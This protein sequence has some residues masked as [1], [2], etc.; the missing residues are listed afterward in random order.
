MGGPGQ[1]G[2]WPTRG[3]RSCVYRLCLPLTADLNQRAS[4]EASTGTCVHT[5]TWAFVDLVWSAS[6]FFTESLLVKATSVQEVEQRSHG[7]LHEDNVKQARTDNCIERTHRRTPPTS[8]RI[9]HTYI[10][11][12]DA[13]HLVCQLQSLSRGL[14]FTFSLACALSPRGI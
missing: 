13:S 8:L 4:T 5:G 6:L 11:A 1:H 9:E 14:T 12:P 10:N 7:T 3:L 2:L